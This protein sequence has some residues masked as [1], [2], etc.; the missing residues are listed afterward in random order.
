MGR[1]QRNPS[2]FAKLHG[3]EEEAAARAEI[4]PVIDATLR[5]GPGDGFR[6]AL[7]ILRGG[8]VRRIT[9]QQAPRRERPL[10]P[11]LDH[12]SRRQRR[13]CGPATKPAWTVLFPPRSPRDRWATSAA[14]WRS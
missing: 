3:G 4:A 6:C 7:L 9:T 2:S 13:S 11:T 10:S 12:P 5:R 1:A 8:S 14:P